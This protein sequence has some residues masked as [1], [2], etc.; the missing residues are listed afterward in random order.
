ML[1]RA[2]AES[3]GGV[4]LPMPIVRSV[5]G[6]LHGIASA[7]LR[8]ARDERSV[9]LADEMLCWTLQFQTAASEG[10]AERMAAGVKARM[11]EIASARG[12]GLRGAEAVSRDERTR[13][14][15]GILRLATREDFR[16]LSVPQIADEANVS[17]DVFCELFDGR[18]DCFTAAL[19]MIGDE[20]LAIAADPDLVS[21]DWPRAVRRVLAEL[22]RYL[23]DHPLQARTLVQEAFFADTAALERTID[24]SHSIATLL[25]EGAP[26]EARG[27]LTTEAVAGAIWHTIRCQVAGGRVELLPALSDHLAYVVLTPFIGAEAAVEI[28]TEERP[29]GAASRDACATGVQQST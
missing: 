14:L 19:D 18:D 25:T 8:E 15:Q 13:L 5:A 17:I 3:P 10:I 27:S 12:N 16:A 6:G 20:L 29:P 23:A 22:M 2:F 4:A 24:L 1:A 9:N 28:L 26:V 21:D 7:F 11:R